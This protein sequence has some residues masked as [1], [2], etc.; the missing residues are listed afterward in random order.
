MLTNCSVQC[1]ESPCLQVCVSND[2]LDFLTEFFTARPELAGLDFF[3][4]G[5]SVGWGEGREA[6]GR[7]E[8]HRR[9]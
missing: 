8:Y 6:T 3:V 7:R 5:E 4:T 9:L 2:M 1:R